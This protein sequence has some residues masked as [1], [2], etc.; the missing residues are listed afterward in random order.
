MKN[1]KYGV[2]IKN[3]KCG[4]L[5]EY[6]LG[7]RNRYD[8]KDGMFTNS[9]LYYYLLD[10][11]LKIKSGFTR[12]IICIE[13]DYGTRSYEEEI[14]HLDKLLKNSNEENKLKIENIKENVEKNKN[15]YEKISKENIRTKFYKSGVNITYNY[16]EE[17]E[18]I[19][20]KMLYR[21]VGKA[22]D[23]SCMFIREELYELAHNFMYMGI[24][25][26]YKN[27]PIVE[28][29]GY[30]PLVA[31]T[32]VDTIKINPKD[33]LI[34]KDIDSYFKTNI[35]SVETDDN[36]HCVAKY[37]ENYELKNTL[38]DG[39]A[40]ID[41][42]IFPSWGN[43]YIL[44]RNHFTKMASFCT[45][46]QKFFKDYFGDNYE[47]ALVEDMF[48][49]KHLAKDIKLIT[50]DN[51]TKW[52]KFGVSYD[53]WCQKVNENFNLFGIVKTAHES[54]MGNVQRMSYQMINSLDL[55]TIS[56]VSSLTIEY[57]ELIK[58]D[59]NEFLKYLK[60]NINFSNDYEVL[61][62]LCN[63]NKEFIRSKY[64]RDRKER[65]IRTYFEEIKSG[66][67]IQNADNLVIVGSPYAMLLHSVG[68]DIKNDNT[69]CVENETIQCFTERF[70]DG[71]Y[72]AGF[73]SP[74]NSQNNL[75]SLHNMYNEKFF[76]YF[77]LGKQIIAINMINTDAQD[78]L[79]GLTK[80]VS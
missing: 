39:Q 3:I 62:E 71:E 24:K 13:F 5:Y 61:L 9:L 59:N 21:S 33:I 44:L 75:V 35:I 76:K 10:H 42:S 22:K 40:L 50:T 8:E 58:K 63:Q 17:S 30:V 26:P 74:H 57:L 49:E 78:R 28:A 66:K 79:N 1:N 11:G 65:I 38:F 55:N 69:F 68:K 27:A 12:D 52:V 53:Y 72:L 46:I 48:G 54:K 15:K 14:E 19:K 51:A 73:R 2:K 23:G 18:T 20:Y 45:H 80:W 16:K 41:S 32:I 36:K 7:L 77:S 34:L 4:S 60:R 64:F 67:L 31:S 43:G 70:E 29:S 37:I 56:D 6:N 25:L 47:T